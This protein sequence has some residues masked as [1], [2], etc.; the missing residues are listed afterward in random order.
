MRLHRRQQGSNG[1]IFIFFIALLIPLLYLKNR[2]YCAGKIEINH[3]TLFTFGFLSY[4]ILP[5]GFVMFLGS[6]VPNALGEQLVRMYSDATNLSEYLAISTLIYFS[7]VSGDLLSRKLRIRAGQHH[8]I[9]ENLLFLFNLMGG[10]I[11]VGAMFQARSVLLTGSYITDVGSQI[12]RG[13]VAAACIFLFSIVLIHLV[14]TRPC[15]VNQLLFNRY[16]LFFWPANLILFLSGT[17]L[18]FLSFVLML[19]VYWTNY[20]S[21]V[22]LS[23]LLPLVVGPLLL[24]GIIGAYR[25]KDG[26]HSIIANFIAEPM[27]TSFSLVDFLRS[28][29]FFILKA[30]VYLASDLLNLVPSA[31][32]PSKTNLMT[33]IPDIYSPLGALNSF[34]SFQ[35]NFGV[36]GTMVFIFF[37]GYG[38]GRLRRRQG[39][40]SK[41]AYTMTSGW[42]AFAFFRDPFSVSLVKDIL[43]FSLILPALVIGISRF[44][45]FAVKPGHIA[46]AEAR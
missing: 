4:W 32:A 18:Y 43:E 30:P 3:V 35:W 16:M 40:W 28:K 8:A 13:P 7:F 5:I 19:I 9:S 10:A 20:V 25:L 27:F 45:A 46:E 11:A 31:L 34:V 36:L 29:H 22:R 44:T 39:L 33:E 15:T 12:A 42:L 37:M 26:D 23:R 24:M 2:T 17:R 6:T 14:Q 21:P 1:M 38:L 41:V